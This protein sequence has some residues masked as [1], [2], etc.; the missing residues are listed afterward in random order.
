MHLWWRYHLATIIILFALILTIYFL[1]P[2]LFYIEIIGVVLILFLWYLISPEI[3]LR[4]IKSKRV[5][6]ADILREFEYALALAQMKNVKIQ[7]VNSNKPNAFVLG[8]LTSYNVIVTRGLIESLNERELISVLLH[9]LH[10]IKNR[11][12]EIQLIYVL[13]VNTFYIYIANYNPLLG[14][15]ELIIGVILLFPIHRLLEKNADIKACRTTNWIP[16]NL[17]NALVKIGYLSRFLPHEII[18]DYS[19]LD[20]ALAKETILRD[21]KKGF[22]FSTHPALSERLR[23]ISKFIR[24]I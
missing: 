18:K 4:I 23:Y 8:N 24:T 20:L 1:V 14:L 15:S 13:I 11:D 2:P 21:E 22:I 5:E 17:A 16:L 12:I 7:E 19:E 3:L 10:H 9:E 6:N